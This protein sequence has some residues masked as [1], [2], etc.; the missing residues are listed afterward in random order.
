[1]NTA[2]TSTAMTNT[3]ITGTAISAG[4]PHPRRRARV[5]DTEISYV[6]V[7]QGDPIV[8]LHGNPTSSYLWPATSFPMSPTSDVASRPIS[9]AWANPGRRRTVPTASPVTPAISMP[10]SR[11]WASPPTSRWCC[12]TG[13]RRSASI[14]PAAT[15]SKFARSLTWKRWWRRVVGTTFRTGA[16]TSAPCARTR[17]SG[18]SSTTMFSSRR[19][20][21]RAL[22]A[23][24]VTPRWTLTASPSCSGT[25]ACRR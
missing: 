22:S 18:S 7:G 2:M 4:D 20:C 1:M 25:H 10:G 23:V 16:T 24:S 14:A 9:S 21:R 11:R 15:R 12:T 3:A 13:A 19:W 5:L 17:A 6:D 8:F